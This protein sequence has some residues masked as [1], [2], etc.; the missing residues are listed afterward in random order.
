MTLDR[1]RFERAGLARVVAPG[2]PGYTDAVAGFDLAVSIAPD[3]VVVA[4][5]ADEVAAA[6]AVAV[7]ADVPLTALGSG[8]GRL[9]GVTGGVA[10]NLRALDAVEIDAAARTARIGAG[11]EW[12][13][14]VAAA[15]AQGLAAP[16]GSAPSVG[17]IGYLLGGGVGPLASTIG[18]SS[19]HVRSF[20]V[21]TAA[22]GP[23]TVSADS[24]PD[25][26]WAMRGGKTGW[27]IVTAVTVDLFPYAEIVGGGMY[28][29]A[30][31]VPAVLSAYAEWSTGLPESSTTSIALL[32]MPP[33]PALPAELRGR[34]VGH[35]RFASVE[36]D[37]EARSQLAALRSVATPV[38]DTI[39]PLPYAQIGSVHAD[40]TVPMPVANGTASLPALT[41]EIVD[42]LLAAGGLDTDLPLSA[43]EIR[44]L[45]AGVRRTAPGTDAVGGRETQQLLNVYAAPDATITDDVRLAAVRTVLD[46][47]ARWQLPTTLINFV[48]RTP[49]RRPRT[50]GV[51]LR[52]RS[53]RRSAG[54]MTRTESS[55]RSRDRCRHAT[56][57]TV[58]INSS[59]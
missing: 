4:Q 1:S 53:S 36:S 15:A 19:D 50:R 25:L 59:H 5:S 20:E 10:V 56:Q 33:A 43:V 54:P 47:P 27:G 42:A 45:G 16:C 14:V 35:V 24:H 46:G 29:D 11:C 12:D 52:A 23:L 55:H 40:P 21:V 48:G 58:W 9:R 30:A 57:R 22:E 51:P 28:F 31:D 41:T 8:H 3:L 37:A 2:D 17:V 13:V 18:V 26:F 39:G 6:V 38:R 34:H 49:P 7:D 44:T 32:R